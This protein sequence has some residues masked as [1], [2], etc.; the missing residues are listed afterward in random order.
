MSTNGSEGSQDGVIYLPIPRPTWRIVRD[1]PIHGRGTDTPDGYRRVDNYVNYFIQAER[2]P[3]HMWPPNAADWGMWEHLPSQYYI[4]PEA[5]G[6][7]FMMLDDDDRLVR[8]DS[9]VNPAFTYR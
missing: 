9:L 4:P 6:E 3:A 7:G 2:C 5:F 1:H 8:A